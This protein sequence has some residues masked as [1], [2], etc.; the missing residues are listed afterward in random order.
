MKKTEKEMEELQER[1][2]PDYFPMANHLSKSEKKRL[3]T[4]DNRMAMLVFW[5][6]IV[7]ALIAITIAIVVICIKLR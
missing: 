6:P 1:D 4:L 3:K 7:H 5:L 2:G